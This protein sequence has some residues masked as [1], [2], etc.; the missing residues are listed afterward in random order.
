[1]GLHMNK[2]RIVLVTAKHIPQGD[3]DT[4]RLM[5]LI[6]NR[7]WSADL[8]IWNDPKVNWEQYDIVFLH[9]A[10]DYILHAEEFGKWVQR[11]SSHVSFVNPADLVL[12]NMDKRY[13]FDL[14]AKGIPLPNT[15]Y[16][17]TG[18]E[19]LAKEHAYPI[20]IKKVVS[21]G[22]RGNW[23][24]HDR[25]ELFTV[26]QKENLYEQPL[27]KQHYEPAIITKG[28]YSAIYLDNIYQF[29]ILKMPRQGEYR[30]QAQYGGSE[31]LVRT[32]KHLIDFTDNVLAS[33]PSK[34]KYA[35]VDFILDEQDIAKLMEVEL[36]EPD[37]F[38]RYHPISYERFVDLL[39]RC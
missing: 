19:L 33:L 31:Q 2:K 16:V 32:E 37:L 30:V 34:P 5:E 9:T 35:R 10:W 38:L 39:G 11:L 1:M 18:R 24:C 20:V 29:T 23:L 27:L 28:E 25:N 4:S 13:L 14:Q 22:G 26:L 36:I 6:R 8:L 15:K 17:N 3:K 21:A 12:W 7:G